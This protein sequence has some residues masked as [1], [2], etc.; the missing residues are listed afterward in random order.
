MST[1]LSLAE[2][3]LVFLNRQ[4]LAAAPNRALGKAGLLQLIDDLGF[5]QVDSIQWVERAHHQILFARNQTYRPEHLKTL[6]EEDGALFEH[7]THDA[8]I[9][10]SH[11]FKY[12]KHRFRWE[13]ET[14]VAR[15][16]RWRGENFHESFDETYARIREGGRVF[17][18]ELKAEGHV[19]GGWWNWHP[20]KTALESLW[21]MGKLAIAGRENFQKI[22]D[23]TER[24]IPTATIRKR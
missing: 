15:W 18:R 16:Q 23:L 11:F 6:L 19:S 9:I 12:W 8:S 20:S 3:R 24:V 22:Y 5:V 7:W 2:A 17:S 4:G 21:R 14:I 13:E 10:P 1:R